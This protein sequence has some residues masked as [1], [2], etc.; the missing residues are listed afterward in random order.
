MAAMRFGRQRAG[1][2]HVIGHRGPAGTGLNTHIGLG[3]SSGYGGVARRF[4]GYQRA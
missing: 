1:E 4:R 2:L 3:W